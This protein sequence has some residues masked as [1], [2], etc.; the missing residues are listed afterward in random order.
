MDSRCF[1]QLYIII[2]SNIVIAFKVRKLESSN[3]SIS[4]TIQKVESSYTIAINTNDY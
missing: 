2:D 4:T 3:L 1:P